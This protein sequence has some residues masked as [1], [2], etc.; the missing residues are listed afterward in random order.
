[1]I[2]TNWIFT[3]IGIF[4]DERSAVLHVKRFGH[5][6]PI[7][8][9]IDCKRNFRCWLP[10]KYG[11]VFRFVSSTI[12]HEVMQNSHYLLRREVDDRVS[13]AQMERITVS[14]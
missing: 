1:V 6:W 10:T 9:V 4:P 3:D 8:S 2:G 12:A 11:Y 5:R 7:L 14:S 13:I